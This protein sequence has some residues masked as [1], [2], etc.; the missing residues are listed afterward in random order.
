MWTG[1]HLLEKSDDG[2]S[3]LIVLGHDEIPFLN[4]KMHSI[5]IYTNG[6]ITINAPLTNA[7]YQLPDTDH[8]L[9]PEHF[10]E[11][12]LLAPLWTDISTINGGDIFYR[13]V[14]D[15]ES[16][17]QINNEINSMH[18]GIEII[19]VISISCGILTLLFL[20]EWVEFGWAF[21]VTWYKVIPHGWKDTNSRNTFQLVIAANDD[22]SFIIFNYDDLSWPN[23]QIDRPIQI[24]YYLDALQKFETLNSSLL[25]AKALSRETNCGV[26]GKFIFRINHSGE[27]FL[28]LIFIN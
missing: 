6:F 9:S 14:L 22:Y 7:P 28:I 21:V 26:Q 3:G 13:H 27:V 12:N 4:I 25:N 15:S 5:Y 16:L 17:M 11:N 20:T 23:S 1:D 10:G 2:N 8:N 19:I 18:S 24:G